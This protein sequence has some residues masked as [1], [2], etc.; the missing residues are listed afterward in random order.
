MRATTE[1]GV[2]K[3]AV[4]LGGAAGVAFFAGQQVLD[5]LPLCVG[6]LVASARHGVFAQKM[7]RDGVGVKELFLNVTTP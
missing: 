5:V 3:E 6:D 7:P 4:V 2:D 1:H